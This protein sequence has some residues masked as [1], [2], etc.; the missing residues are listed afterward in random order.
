[1]KLLVNL[2]AQDGI[3]S[4]N[5]G[6]GTMLKRYIKTL[7]KIFEDNSI[8]YF[9]NLFTP[10]YLS[11]GF[12]YSKETHNENKTLDNVNIFQIPN[13]SNGA[14]FFGTLYNWNTLC[15]NTKKIID[16]ENFNEYDFVITIA[17]D[18]PFAGLMYMCDEK[19]NHIKVWIPHST[20]KIH[21]DI[22]V[23]NNDPNV[24]PRI[25]W[26][27]KAITSINANKNCYV[28]VVGKFIKQHLISEYL[29][30]KTKIVDLYNG[31]LLF[32]DTVYNID[33]KT[34]KLF[35]NIQQDQDI[36]MSFGRP[37]PYKNLDATMRLAHKLNMQCIIITQEYFK[38]M[39]YVNYLKQLAKETNSLL[40][41]NAP[42][43]FPQYIL[44]N[45]TKRIILV[46]PS[47]KEIAGLVLNEVRKLNKKNIL[48]VV[49][50][51]D[52]LKE[53]VNDVVDG[54]LINLEDIDES[55]KKV[56][57]NFNDKKIT[58]INKNSL[59]RLNKDYNFETNMKGFLHTLL[60][61]NF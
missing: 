53:Q 30:D 22:L 47:K 13:G 49:N 26:E 57:D 14:K 40:F 36:V 8:E 3:V 28:G 21:Q 5:S 43:H 1:M 10:E 9:I 4:H 17:N 27:N 61:I 20:A 12:G 7:C 55:A 48:L 59:Y 51:I 54:I 19:S 23:Q 34:I 16:R 11:N 32:E 45:Y 46:V 42:F 52:G 18:T 41:I 31:E 6:V 29:V 37:E 56:K 58:E 44:N 39:P 33:K 24:R 60:K 2:C 15:N 35:D 25:D 38:N 50:N